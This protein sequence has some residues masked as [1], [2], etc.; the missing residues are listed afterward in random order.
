[1]IKARFKRTVEEYSNEYGNSI[2]QW[3]NQYD[4][5]PK[6]MIKISL[7]FFFS[8]FLI[9]HLFINYLLGVDKKEA[10]S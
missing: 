6:D 5:N 1:M 9:S 7:G 8:K 2:S 4:H 10:H 3:Y